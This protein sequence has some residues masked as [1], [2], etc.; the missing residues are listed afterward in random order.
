MG[1]RSLQIA[2]GILATIPV[3]A[4]AAAFYFGVRAP[5]YRLASACVIPTMDSNYRFLGGE[6]LGIGLAAFWLIP[7]IER[8][9]TLFRAIWIA[10]FIGG[11]GRT[12]SLLTLGA[13]VPQYVAFLVVE[14]LGAPV[15]IYW[16]SR[17][18]KSASVSWSPGEAA[19]TA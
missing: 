6:W 18:A 16:Q 9:T 8:E 1:R 15:F 19:A 5:I 10:I 11:I 13:P 3:V 12:V 4:G 17:V 14:T 7:R 2:T